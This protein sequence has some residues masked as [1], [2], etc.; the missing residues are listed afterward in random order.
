MRRIV[1]PVIFRRK[2]VSVTE[3]V[4][5]L[6]Q[7]HAIAPLMISAAIQNRP[8]YNAHPIPVKSSSIFFIIKSTFRKSGFFYLDP[9]TRPADAHQPVLIVVGVAIG[10]FV[11]FSD[12]FFSP[13]FGEF[14][15]VG[16]G[17]IQDQRS[18][19]GGVLS[20]ESGLQFCIGHVLA[21]CFCNVFQQVRTVI[22]VDQII[23]FFLY[24]FG[25]DFIDRYLSFVYCKVVHDRAVFSCCVCH[26]LAPVYFL[27]VFA[28][29][30]VILYKIFCRFE[31]NLQEFL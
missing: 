18:D 14:C 25:M 22:A 31:I 27:K 26:F 24:L 3:I 12:E 2:D 20:I 11:F 7:C 28:N 21:D 10:A 23:E 5:S 17:E 29:L 16:V 13:F 19:H 6:C 4:F 8:I 9:E 30:F 15:P 1:I